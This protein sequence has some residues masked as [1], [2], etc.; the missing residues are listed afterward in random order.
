MQFQVKSGISLIL[1]YVVNIECTVTVVIQVTVHFFPIHLLLPHHHSMVNM[2][3]SHHLQSCYHPRHSVVQCLHT[4]ADLHLLPVVRRHVT[5]LRH[6]IAV[7]RH[8]VTTIMAVR[9]LQTVLQDCRRCPT[10]DIR[11]GVIGIRRETTRFIL[12]CRRLLTSAGTAVR[13]NYRIVTAIIRQ[14]LDMMVSDC[15]LICMSPRILDSMLFYTNGLKGG[16]HLRFTIPL[17]YMTTLHSECYN[18]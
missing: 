5:G 12:R 10:V 16:A 8:L 7:C 6:D 14:T 17:D 9:R 3:P 13:L 4:S 18:I 2:D 15:V 11:R 1:I